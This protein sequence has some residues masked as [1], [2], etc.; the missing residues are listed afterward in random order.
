MSKSKFNLNYDYFTDTSKGKDPDSHSKNLNY[1]HQII[2]SKRLP[3]GEMFDLKPLHT[4]GRRLLYHKSK[5]L[6]EHVLASDA[7]IHPLYYYNRQEGKFLDKIAYANSFPS[8]QIKSELKN[9]IIDFNFKA[10][11]LSCYTLF[12]A[13]QILRKNTI[14]QARGVNRKICDRVD[15]TLECIRRYYDEIKQPNPLLDTLKR[16]DS[17]FKLFG[18]FK[19]YVDF[20]LLQDL[21]SE[22]YSSVHFWLPLDEFNRSPLPQSSNEYTLYMNK[23]LNFIK[24]RSER[25]RLSKEYNL[26]N[27]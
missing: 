1:H 21:V 27:T 12:P 20:F 9:K 17:F 6:G 8:A 26:N 2:W 14:N 5:K 7:I 25:I 22:N 10:V 24:A 15:L 19:G 4:N 13:K 16:Y 18:S 11:G 3:S 23:A